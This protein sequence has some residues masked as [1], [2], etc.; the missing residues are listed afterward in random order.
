MEQTFAQA[1][2]RRT[3][4]FDEVRALEENG[5]SGKYQKCDQVGEEVDEE[6]TCRPKEPQTAK[7][8]PRV[9]SRDQKTKVQAETLTEEE[10]QHHLSDQSG[11]R[12]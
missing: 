5:D 3:R 2:V 12:T 9:D 10:A 4:I 1:A 7:I 8:V 11:T 6:D